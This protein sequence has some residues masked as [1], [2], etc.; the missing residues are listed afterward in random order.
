MSF[1]SE[2]TPGSVRQLR[3]MWENKTAAALGPAW[4][5]AFAD[6]IKKFGFGRVADAVQVASAAGYPED[7]E[8]LPPDIRNVPK[9]AAV[10]QADER[11][12]GMRHCY[13]VRGRMR[14]KFYCREDDS[15][16]LSLLRRAMR[17]G[18]SA[19]A[20]HQAVDESNT[21][22]DCF[23]LMG[24]ERFEFR[25]AMDRPIIDLPPKHQVFIRMEDP[26]W[27]IWDA[28]WRRTK[29][30]GAPM[31]KHFGWFFSSRLPPTDPRS[32]NASGNQEPTA[33]APAA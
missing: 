10:Q 13:L 19:S 6:W 3:E 22:E 18:V 8:R 33:G 2:A 4:N 12:P 14:Q 30:I 15:E 28:Y 24:F 21:L 20:M 25:I 27:P 16:V 17:A 1:E 9:Y 7:G 5:A 11:E 29:G 32:R 31:N 23:V 26:E